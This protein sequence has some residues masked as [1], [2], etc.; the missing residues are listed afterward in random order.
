MN[1]P[2]EHDH[3]PPVQ[4]TDGER[5]S[6]VIGDRVCIACG[7]NLTGQ[8][9][10]KE[11]TY[12]LFIAR[13]PECGGVA[14]MQ[15]YPVLGK[16]ANRWATLA[17]ALWLAVLFGVFFGMGVG[18]FA[19]SMGTAQTVADSAGRAIVLEWIDTPSGQQALEKLRERTSNP[20]ATLGRWS[21]IDTQW[22][23]AQ[24]GWEI[25]QKQGG[26]RKVI[27]QP[28]IAFWSAILVVG[29]LGGVVLSVALLHLPKRRLM[30][31]VLIPIAIAATFQSLFVTQ[32]ITSP[33][34]GTA[35]RDVALKLVA[36]VTM[37]ST[38]VFAYIGLIFGAVIGR[39]IARGLVIALLPPRMRSAM[40][41][42]WI[43]EGKKP[44]KTTP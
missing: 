6:T 3:S 41:F 4:T 8:P 43:A 2:E 35:V 20:T 10:V 18:F 22:W 38:D 36:P 33:M 19:T 5:V 9:V 26:W 15:E 24:N 30:L 37:A 13:C 31:Y 34:F 16:W 28:A 39:S 12:N 42:L 32:A 27:V 21:H 17:A 7:F 23:N 1:M 40:S 29:A 14:S 11:S 25:L 44:P